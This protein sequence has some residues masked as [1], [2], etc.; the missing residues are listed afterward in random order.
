MS[1]GA[2]EPPSAGIRWLRVAIFSGAAITLYLL[3]RY[4]ADMLVHQFG[5][6]VGENN[7]R[8]I[9]HAIVTAT[10]VYIV[11][12]VVPFMPAAE[13]GVSMLMLFGAKIAFLVY[14]STVVALTLAFLIGRL[15]PAAFV[16]RAFGL[17]G[18]TRAQNF[19]RRLAPLS[20]E[21]RKSVLVHG[22]PTRLIPGI[23]RHRFVAL[24]VL[25]N[26]PG[27]VV[28]GGGGGIALLAGMS[29]L[30]PLPAYLLTVALA[31]APVP[32]FVSLTA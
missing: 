19:I 18:L 5:L 30:F 12:M 14:A 3:G 21:E 2:N 20:A 4:V 17:V 9:H 26:I 23:V 27:N 24:A 10:V 25:L 8:L 22:A 15:V 16:A 1:E 29:R 11:F 28:I 6:D 32:L 31:V 13:I 7:E